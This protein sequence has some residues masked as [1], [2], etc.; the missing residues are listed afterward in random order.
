MISWINT[1]THIG[2][3]LH[4]LSELKDEVGEV[5]DVNTGQRR[6]GWG[7]QDHPHDWNIHFTKT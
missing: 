2:A 3:M 5:V 4:W 1:Q 6:S 7:I